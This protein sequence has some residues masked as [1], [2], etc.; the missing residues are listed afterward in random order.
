MMLF[1]LL[2]IPLVTILFISL[3]NKG[4]GNVI[5][6]ISSFIIGAI[7][8][9]PGIFLFYLF[10]GIFPL[11]FSSSALYLHFMWQDHLLHAV[12]ST[13]GLL[14]FRA[15]IQKTS[16]DNYSFR[17]LAY[18]GGYYTLVSCFYFLENL[19]HL[20]EYIL[21]ILPLL[22]LSMVLCTSIAVS[23]FHSRDGLSRIFPILLLAVP[24]ALFGLISTGPIQNSNFFPIVFS[25]LAAGASVFGF[26]R[27]KDY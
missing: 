27:L 26:V 22:H 8:F 21:F 6:P 11:E 10:R 23:Q 4:Q 25:A 3:W 20:N 16:H 9:F 19:T 5:F 15:F 24:I 14:I 7:V 12:F 1:E 2:L 17:A 18:Y 13:T